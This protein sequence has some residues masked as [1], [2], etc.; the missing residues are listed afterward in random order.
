[1]DLC[2]CLILTDELFAG[3]DLL[4]ATQKKK[5]SFTFQV[6]YYVLRILI[7][8]KYIFCTLILDVHSSYVCTGAFVK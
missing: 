4:S 3:V 8:F 1:M 7:S 6:H 2:V 5:K